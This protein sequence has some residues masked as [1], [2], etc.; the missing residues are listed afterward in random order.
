[1][2]GTSA[3]QEA[4]DV[5]PAIAPVQVVNDASAL[6]PVLLSPSAIFGGQAPA[7]AGNFAS[8]T[9]HAAGEGGSLA[10]FTLSS[11]LG[12]GFLIIDAP[13]AGLRVAENNAQIMEP[14]CNTKV[15]QGFYA[16]DQIQ[17]LNPRLGVNAV[18][19]FD[20]FVPSGKWL[21]VQALAQNAA[22]QGWVTIEEPPAQRSR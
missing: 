8:L 21:L 22:I 5:L 7:V 10:S 3:D 19:T 17:G 12:V 1:M 13:F 6:A 16:I 15:W 18:I 9:V 14:G 4:V 2:G 20:A 11:G